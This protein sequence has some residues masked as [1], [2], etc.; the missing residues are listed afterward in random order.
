MSIF[1]KLKSTAKETL[2]G[3]FD[4]SKTSE[5]ISFAALPESLADMQALPEASLDSPYKAA[6]L[7]VCAL[8]AYAADREIGSEMLNWLRGPAGPMSN[9]DKQ[10]LNER[11]SD[12]QYYVPFSFFDGTSPENDYTPS[13]PF[14]IQMSTNSYSF[15]NEGY[16]V[17]WIKSSGA[18][19]PR[20]ITLRQKGNQ[21]FLWQQMLLAGIRK[22]KSQDPWA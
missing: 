10:F 11:F 13:E 5:T 4:K 1:D 22:P 12:N 21:W 17:V 15:Q 19:S 6:A 16:A 8:C 20:Q 9:A 7:S 3:V 14:T 2:A 18:D